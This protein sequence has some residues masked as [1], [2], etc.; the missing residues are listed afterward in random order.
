M[1][2]PDDPFRRFRILYH[3]TDTRNLR[4]IREQ[5][6]ILSTAR[7]RERQVE[8][9]AGGDEASLAN[10]VRSGLDRYVRLC[11]DERHPMAHHVELR[12]PETTLTYLQ[13]S[14]DIVYEPDV[15]YSTGVAYAAGVEI[16]PLRDAIERGMVD[17]EVLYTFMPWRD[18]VVQQRRHAAELCEILVP[19]EV[20]L[21]FIRNMP[22]G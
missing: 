5:R 3:F 19:D 6:G 7:L 9:F 22:N 21:T 15:M 13:I 1:R 14:R 4:S 12:N 2:D 18:P 10:D 16:V 11:F 20:A 17:F 8:F